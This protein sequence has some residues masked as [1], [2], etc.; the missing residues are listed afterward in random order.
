MLTDQISSD[1]KDAMKA[2]DAPRLSTLRML[3]AALK[4]KQID[5]M[6][7]LSDEEA[8]AVVKSQVKQLR[9]AAET[10]RQAGR[11]ELADAN[12]REIALLE[13][14]LPSQLD[15]ASLTA[16]VQDAVAS[17]G[18]SSKADAGKAMGAAMKAVAGRADGSRVKTIVNSLLALFALLAVFACW[19]DPAL[20]ANAKTN[21]SAAASGARILRV[22]LMLMGIVSV[23]FILMGAVSIMTSSGRDH[24]H[25]HGIQ[26]IAIGIFGTV[27]MAAL[28]AVVSIAISRLG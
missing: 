6:H 12:D 17:V 14:Y 23:N 5:L 16:I 22:F 27:I 7:E 2:Q 25:H 11:G 10:F 9:D 13:V 20:A 19:F 4:N 18:A 26:Q 24:E 1:L 3:K 28:I 21:A 8:L 15:D